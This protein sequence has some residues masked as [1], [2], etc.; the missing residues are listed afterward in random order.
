MPNQSNH[1]EFLTSPHHATLGLLT[2]GVG[3]LTATALGL[4]IGGVAYAL[5]M[6]YLPDSALFTGWLERR[7]A[8]AAEAEEQRVLAEFGR[9]RSMLLGSLLGERPAR[10]A[11]MAQV[12]R[13]IEEAGSEQQLAGSP[14]GAGDARMR[15][16]DELMWTFLRLL[17]F[18]QSLE[19]YVAI[20]Q[21]ENLPQQLQ[22]AETD[23]ANLKLTFEQ[24]KAA[25]A[26]DVDSMQRLVDSRQELLDVLTK[27]C[28]RAEQAQSNLALVKSELQR[29]EQQ[30]KLVRADAV[31]SKNADALSARINATV[32]HLEQT[33]RWLSEMDEFKDLNT[34]LPDTSKRV[35]FEA[36]AP[37]PVPEPAVNEPSPFRNTTK[38]RTPPPF[39]ETRRR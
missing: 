28:Q 29:L 10:Y 17:A 5:G 8:E 14:T 1:K 3:L 21:Q 15:K 20:E 26:A 39:Q 34:G 19:K 7:R 36:E 9:R 24:K 16:L 35:G 25:Q 23:L 13:D 6:I 11:S 27:R 18:E 2:L 33:N 30:I 22:Y 37:P 32:D 38:V 4:I 12:C 31:A